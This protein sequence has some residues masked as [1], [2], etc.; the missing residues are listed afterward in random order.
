MVKP[1]R[2]PGDTH[3]PA[4]PSP[5][6]LT[7]RDQFAMAALTGLLANQRA[8]DTVMPHHQPLHEL[9]LVAYELADAMLSERGE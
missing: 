3:S 7:L 2:P 9:A 4:R 5:P 6:D 8:W 1:P